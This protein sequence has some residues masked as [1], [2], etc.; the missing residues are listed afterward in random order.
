MKEGKKIF[1]HAAND[2]YKP[3]MIC[4]FLHLYEFIVKVELESK[5]QEHNYYLE[6][7]KNAMPFSHSSML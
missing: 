2:Q 5:K 1:S 3:I 6:I 7:P 4:I